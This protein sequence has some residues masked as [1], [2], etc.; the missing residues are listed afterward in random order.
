[1]QMA[2]GLVMSQNAVR[3]E[4]YSARPGAPIVPHVERR[5]RARAL[6]SAV[7]AALDRT[8]RAS[9]RVAGQVSS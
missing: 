9:S 7:A 1:M 3:D 5:P 6:R 2:V 8:A 4:L